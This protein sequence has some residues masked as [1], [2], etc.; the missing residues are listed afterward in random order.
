MA[1]LSCNTSSDLRLG[2]L[3]PAWKKLYQG[4]MVWRVQPT[5]HWRQL[6]SLKTG[7]LRYCLPRSLTSGT[8]QEIKNALTKPKTILSIK[9][10]K[11]ILV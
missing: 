9:M 5:R 3:L 4:R 11:A 7:A 8:D 6:S 1:L 10:I 2:A